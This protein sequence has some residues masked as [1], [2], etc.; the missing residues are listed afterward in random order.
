MPHHRLTLRDLPDT[1]ADDHPPD[2]H[3]GLVTGHDHSLSGNRGGR[4]ALSH[5]LDDKL[6]DRHGRTVYRSWRNDR[7]TRWPRKSPDR[8]LRPR[9]HTVR[10]G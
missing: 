5:R 1:L 6:W 4:P 3:T 2:A 10:C 7:E 9:P 8:H